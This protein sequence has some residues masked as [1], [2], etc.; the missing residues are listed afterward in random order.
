[1]ARAVQQKSEVMQQ[2]LQISF[3][4]VDPSPALEARVR[5]LAAHLERFQDRITS[6]HVHIEAPHRRHHQGQLYDVRIQLRV[7]G[8]DIVVNHEGSNN[9]AYEDVYVALRDAFDAAA[10]RLE[11]H[12]RLRDHRH[13]R[14]VHESGP[15]ARVTRLFPQDGYGF[16]E[17]DDGLE[18]YFHEHSVLDDGFARLEVGAEVR[19]E[20]AEQE[21]EKGPQAT[22][23]RLVGKQHAPG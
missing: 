4:D 23:V 10:R 18:V 22:T 2:P 12:A 21:S 19:L 17:T 14:R 6:C 20:I 1:M 3:H 5:E 16:V 9:H 11:D 15:R 8:K 7:P 13:R